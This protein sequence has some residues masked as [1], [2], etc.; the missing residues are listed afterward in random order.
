[1]NQVFY[2]TYDL[3]YSLFLASNLQIYA[4]GYVNIKTPHAILEYNSIASFDR[5]KH[6]DYLGK[7]AYVNRNFHN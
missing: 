3:H 4:Y 2:F 7:L 1:M 6:F 5:V